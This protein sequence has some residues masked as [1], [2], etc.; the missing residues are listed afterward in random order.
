MKILIDSLGY[1]TSAMYSEYG[2]IY[3]ANG[4]KGI[5]VSDIPE[6]EFSRF[7]EFM[8]AYKYY[9][10]NGE[11][12]FDHTKYTSIIHKKELDELRYRRQK[13]CFDI[14]DRSQLWYNSLTEEQLSELTEWYNA[15]L[16]VTE[17]LTPPEKPAWL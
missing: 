11:V 12:K 10:D 7:Q 4:N 8:E 2:D 16:K 17:T 5:L 15:W 14:V 9:P 13:E 6:D 1:V 3:D